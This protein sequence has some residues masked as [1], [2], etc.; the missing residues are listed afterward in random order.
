MRSALAARVVPA[1]RERGMRGSFPHFRR[2]GPSSTDL[3]TFQFDKYGGGFVIELGVGPADE[4]V[5]DWGARI[6]AGRLTAFDVP[7]AA[8]ARLQP[9]PGSA[10]SWFRYEAGLFRRGAARF[11]RAARQVLEVLPHADAW[12][13]GDRPQRNVREY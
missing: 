4:F 5:T 12:W 7:L 6:P 13:R 11:E 9:R 8:R 3:L 2:I 10:D 1:L